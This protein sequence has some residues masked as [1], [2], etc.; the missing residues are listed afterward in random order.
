MFIMNN[1]FLKKSAYIFAI[2]IF[3]ILLLLTGIVFHS[4]FQEDI[5]PYK[6][7]NH[8]DKKLVLLVL[9][10]LGIDDLHDSSLKNFNLLIKKSAIGVMNTRVSTVTSTKAVAAYASIGAGK[11]VEITDKSWPVFKNDASNKNE[12]GKIGEI[13]HANNINVSLIGNADTDVPSLN[14][15]YLV[16]DEKGEVPVMDNSSDLLVK[17]P[18]APWGYRTNTETLLNKALQAI[19]TNRLTCIDFGD[20]YRVSQAKF[21]FTQDEYSKLRKQA[22]ARADL[23]LGELLKRLDLKKTE[24]LIISPNPASGKNGWNSD[25]L[26]PVIYYNSNNKPGLIYSKTTKREGLVSYI[27]IAPTI[28]HDLGVNAAPMFQ[29]QCFNVKADCLAYEKVRQNIKDFLEIK[30]SRYIIHGF[31]VSMLVV[32]LLALY[33]PVFKRKKIFNER[34]SRCFAVMVISIPSISI[35]LPAIFTLKLHY[36]TGLLC[37][38]TVIVAGFIFSKSAKSAG[39][40]MFLFSLALSG[41]IIIDTLTRKNLLL[42]TPLGFDDIFAGGRFYGI[43]N[44]CMGILI[45]SSFFSLFY[46]LSTFNLKKE[47]QFLLILFIGTMVV[48]TQIPAYGANVGG[49][50]AALTTGILSLNSVIIK[51]N[52]KSKYIS[53]IG[54]VIFIEIILA[55]SDFLTGSQTHAGR[56]ISAVING[57][58]SFMN[59]YEIIKSKSIL[60]LLMLIIPPWNILFFS[61]LIVYRNIKNKKAKLFQIFKKNNEPMVLCFEV[62]TFSALTTLIFND[63]GIIATAIIF[64][65]ITMPLGVLLFDK[66]FISHEYRKTLTQKL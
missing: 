43:N 24:L 52:L 65:Y 17:D 57:E 2:Y 48:L 40:A 4:P 44:D 62:L 46:I 45:G 51:N 66:N 61:Q 63:T 47:K 10:N 42:N 59:V 14:S 30:R 50:I 26:T 1:K 58:H 19:N 53:T 6:I 27:D 7:K 12:L 38:A 36:I 8:S 9:D 64:T 56:A 23:F 34:V 22:L 55:Y 49:T 18:M 33:L 60:F 11:R 37:I 41:F 13:A 32:G 31:Y 21:R 16:M 54:M 39:W 5:K 20:T 25:F 35:I 15:Y 28:F 3:T 29:G